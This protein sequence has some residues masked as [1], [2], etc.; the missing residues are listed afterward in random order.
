MNR[1]DLI[2]FK[3][4][5]SCNRITPVSFCCF[6][7]KKEQF[8]YYNIDNECSYYCSICGSHNINNN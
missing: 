7:C 6:Y 4:L 8:G 2:R 1:F 5:D 3:N